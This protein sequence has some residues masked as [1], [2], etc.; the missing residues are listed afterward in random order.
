M[1]TKKLLINNPGDWQAVKRGHDRSV[2]GLAVLVTALELKSKMSR[3]IS[4]FVVA[5]EKDNLV[6]KS[7]LQCQKIEKTFER[8]VAAVDV[9]SEEDEAVGWWL[10]TCHLEHLQ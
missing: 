5:S 10:P 8:E 3:Q 2:Y 9:I 6:G 1:R 7:N 4:A